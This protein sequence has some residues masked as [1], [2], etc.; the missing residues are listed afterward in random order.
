MQRA[1][2]GVGEVVTLVVCNQINDAALRESRR[3]V[4]NEPPFLNAGS[5]RAHATTVGRPAGSSKHRACQA[6]EG[7]FDGP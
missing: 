2:L 5:K 4:E 1:A 3:F 6:P 7:R